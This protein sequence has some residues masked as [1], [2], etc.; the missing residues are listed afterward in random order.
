VVHGEHTVEVKTGAGAEAGAGERCETRDAGKKDNQKGDG[1]P[2]DETREDNVH[3]MRSRS[4]FK[5]SYAKK[6]KKKEKFLETRWNIIRAY[7]QHTPQQ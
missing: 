5:K 7:A 6:Q 1:E 3:N 4:N 2:R